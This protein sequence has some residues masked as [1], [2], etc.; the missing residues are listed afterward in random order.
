MA[1][2][3]LL[4][5][6]KPT[7]NTDTLLYSAPIDSS[8]STVLN[9][10]NDGTGSVYDVAIKNYDQ[11]LTLDAS[12]YKLHKGDVITS[13]RVAFDIAMSQTT[14]ITATQLLETTDKEKSFRFES[15][16]VP[17]T[18]SI[19]V[20]SL[21]IRAVTVESITG[22]F[23]AGETISKGVSPDDTTAIVYGTGGSG[24]I[25]YIGVSTIN[26]G[27]T[28]FGDGDSITSSGG[29][30]ATISVG[31]VAT[32]SDQ[33]VF[34][35]TTIGGTYDIYKK[36]PLS[37][38][39]DRVYRFDVSDSSM[40][41]RDFK[42]SETINGEW[43]PD[44]IF[45]TGDDGVEYTTGKTTNGTAGSGGAYIQY[46]FSLPATPTNIYFYDGGTGTSGNSA[47]GGSDRALIKNTSY[48]YTEIYVYSVNG[49]LTN[50]VDTFIF[51]GVTYTVTGTTSGPYGYVRDYSGSTLTFI[52]GEGSADWVGTDT[53]KDVPKDNTAD[54][55]TATVSAVVV[56]T[57]EIEAS[58][59]IVEGL[60][61][62]NNEVDKITSLVIGAGE[63]VI[64]N[65]FTAN[66]VFSLIG[67]EDLS[68]SITTRVFGQV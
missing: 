58:N 64:V 5:Q 54:R 39:G 12:T 36:A 27:G 33:F 37:F 23:G 16:Y 66:N 1:D 48:E 46:D 53:F 3:G 28:E 35:N 19:F 7:A 6:L 22:T 18:T 40:T 38:F 2:Q 15:F 26:G 9:I 47:F 29:A 59:Y 44:N 10:S 60:T 49:T 21:S 42:L 25:L 11:K 14:G 41:G 34:S 17:E 62:G 52:K 8:A 43:G 65:S 30:A 56:N 4:A 24:D 67:F 45:G 61:N 31:G 51:D 32:A 20:K 57:S 68:S 50:N 55:S 63:R 13:Y